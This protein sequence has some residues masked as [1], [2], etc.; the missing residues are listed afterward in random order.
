MAILT[1]PEIE[2]VVARTRTMRAAG[3]APPL[4]SIDVDPWV[5][6]HVGPNSVDLTLA[7]LLRIYEAWTF[8]LALDRDDPTFDIAIPPEGIT[9]KPGVLYL[10]STVERTA[11]EGLAPFI[12]GRSSVARKGVSVHLAAG[13]GDDGFDG[14]WTLEITVVHPV[15]VKPGVRICQVAFEELVGARRPYRGRYAG[16]AGPVASRFHLGDGRAGV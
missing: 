10:G 9:L 16:Q 14:T 6:E 4:P 15:L 8:G 3:Q 5:P 11:C 2:R 12:E 1:G 7:P 13:F